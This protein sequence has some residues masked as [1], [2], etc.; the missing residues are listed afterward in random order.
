MLSYSGF[1]QTGP[2]RSR[3]AY[4]VNATMLSGLAGVTG[5]PGQIPSE[6]G[7]S[8]ADANA[9]LHG[10]FA[11]LCALRLRDR[12]GR[13]QY[14]DAALLE[15]LVSV[16]AEGLLPW[17]MRGEQ[18]QPIGNHDEFMAPHNVYPCAGDDRWVSIV[19]RDDGEWRRFADAVGEPL[20]SDARFATRA[21]RKADEAEL[22]GA[23]AR[24]TA[25]RGAWEVTRLLQ[26]K[27]IPAF[28]LLDAR[29]VAEDP[30]LN[31]RR[32][33][34]ELPHREVGVRRHVGPPWR[35]AASPVGVSKAAPCMGEDT[36]RVVMHQLGR[37]RAEYEALRA[38]GVVCDLRDAAAHA[39]F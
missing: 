14:I 34:V 16:T 10:A 29:D 37:S 6:V 11:I 23:I 7:I 3:V 21:G 24:W 2:F 20:A 32:L 31:A 1:G 36:E 27:G 30:H 13:G 26:A 18:V 38:A 5:H 33:F 22:D 12:T 25:G 8:Y 17:T 4:G 19:V 15:A 39:E 28:P 35:F 9:A